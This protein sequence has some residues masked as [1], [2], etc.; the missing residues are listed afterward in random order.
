MQRDPIAKSDLERG[1]VIR[2]HFSKGY[3]IG[4]TWPGQLIGKADYGQ[5]ISRG[6]PED[7]DKYQDAVDTF[8]QPD[9]LAIPDLQ[10][11][12]IDD[13]S[14][15]GG[16]LSAETGSY[17]WDCT[18]ETGQPRQLSREADHPLLRDDLPQI[19]MPGNLPLELT[20]GK[21]A[22]QW[23][24]R[25]WPVSEKGDESLPEGEQVTPTPGAITTD[26]IDPDQTDAGSALRAVIEDAGPGFIY[27]VLTEWEQGTITYSFEIVAR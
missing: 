10:F 4:M 15:C 23:E 13:I 11:T 5:I 3:Y 25:R 19:S 27:Q 16:S 24:V 17:Q 7:A 22:L 20:L 9:L 6:K 18:D 12:Y 14:A 1:N 26:G 21:D 8:Y 2:L